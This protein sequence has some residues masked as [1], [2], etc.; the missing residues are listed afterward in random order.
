M[1][2]PDRSSYT[3]LD[4][5]EW[6]TADSLV[7][8]P[9]FQRRGVWSS[10][11]RSY[12]IDSILLGVPI[13]PLYLRVTQNAQRSKIVREV[14][15]GQQRISAVLDFINGKYALSTNIDNKVAGKKFSQLSDEQKDKIRE[16][17]FFCEVFYGLDDK[18]VLQMFARLNTYSVAL[19]AQE[20]RNGRYFGYFKRSMY[21]LAHEHLEFWRGAKIFSERKIARM[22]EVELTSELAIVLMGGLQDKKKC[23]DEYYAKHDDGFQQQERICKRFRTVIDA[24][25]DSCG[26]VLKDTEFQRVPLFYSLFAVV[27]HRLFGIPGQSIAGGAKQRFSPSD[28]ERLETAVRRLSEIVSNAKA[29]DGAVIAPSYERFVTACLQQTDNLKPREERFTTLYKAAF[30]K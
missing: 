9:K 10:A 23:L 29:E 8:S 17:P 15:D 16:Y 30:V 21:Q 18:D 1:K 5:Q 12:L 7:L 3:A 4:F 6:Q 13:P 28:G 11:A 20:L 22:A 24:I 19:N 2:K 14:I 26:E 27:A 25:S